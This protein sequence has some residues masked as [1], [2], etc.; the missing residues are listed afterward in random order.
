MEPDFKYWA[1][2]SYS[3]RDKAWADWLHS[4]LEGF[5]VPAR[6]RG[7]PSRDGFV[8]RRL[9]PCF[10]DREELPSSASLGDNI[11]DALRRS[12]YLI[13]ICSPRSAVSEWVNKEVLYFKS[14]GREDRVLCLIVDGEPNAVPGSGTLECFP[15]AVRFRVNAQAEI[16]PGERVEPIAADVR[17][18]GDG[19]PNAKLKLLAGLLGV[20]FDELKQRERR[21]VI[22]R[23]LVRGAVAAVLLGVGTWWLL[24]K[25]TLEI[26]L[27]PKPAPR[28]LEFTVDG[29]PETLASERTRLRLPAGN[30]VLRFSAPDHAP[31]TELVD[32]ERRQRR[33]ITA[34][35]AHLQGTLNVEVEPGAAQLE[36]DGKPFG[37]RIDFLSFDT[38]EHVVRA[39]L[40]GHYERTQRVTLREGETLNAYLSLDP[41]REAWHI[42]R[43]DVQGAF[44]N[45][46]DVDGDGVED[47]AHNFITQVG[48]ISGRTGRIIRSF[49][50]S[51]GNA[52]PFN[53]WDLGGSVGRILLSVGTRN[54]RA[55]DGR[56]LIDML[57]LRGDRDQPLW[58]WLSPIPPEAGVQLAV[59]GDQN[60]DGVAE[61]VVHGANDTYFLVDGATGRDLGTGKLGTTNEWAIA[62]WVARCP[63]PQG[64]ALLFCGLLPPGGSGWGE[65]NYRAGLVLI[66]DGR[67]LWEETYERSI[68]FQM[69]EIEGK[70]R[71]AITLVTRTDWLVI[72]NANGKPKWRGAL[73]RTDI[74]RDL[75]GFWFADLDGDGVKEWLMAFRESIAE[76]E[77]LLAAVRLRDGEVLW[78][79][80]IRPTAIQAFEE[81]ALARTAEGGLLFRLETAVVSL[82]PATGNER[83]RVP[84][85]PSGD[86]DLRL[87]DFN[88][89]GQREIVVGVLDKGIRVLG[90]DG[91]P[92]WGVWLDK[93]FSP[94]IVLREAGHPE[95]ARL[96]LNHHDG[97]EK[98]AC[99]I[100][101]VSAP[102]GGG[103][104]RRVVPE[105]ALAAAGRSA[106]SPRTIA[107]GAWVAQ[108][109][110]R[111]PEQPNLTAFDPAT[112][113]R[114]WTVPEVFESES[115][116]AV[117]DW[118][119]QPAL[120]LLGHVPR[121]ISYT[122]LN[123][124]S[125]FV[126]RGSDGKQLAAIPIEPWG[127]WQAT[128]VLAD[129]DGDNHT[130]FVVVRPRL[131]NPYTGA[132][133]GGDVIAVNGAKQAQMWRVPFPQPAALA[134]VGTGA[135]A[136]V[137]VT[138]GDGTLVALT[139]RDGTEVWRARGSGGTGAVAT[140]AAGSNLAGAVF[141]LARDGSF[142]QLDLRTGDVRRQKRIADATKGFGPPVC[143]PLPA[144]PLV[145]VACGATG[146]VAL[147]ALT[148][149]ERWRS[150]AG[151]SVDAP[152]FVADLDSDG[153]LEVVLCSEA[154]D[155]MV[156]DLSTG[157]V[158]RKDSLVESTDGAEAVR[159]V[160]LLTVT[161]ARAGIPARLLV[162][163]SDGVLH[164]KV[165]GDLRK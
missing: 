83:W 2:V 84:N 47:F 123:R 53:G 164:T 126:Y 46:G 69:S 7:R 14:L 49:P 91:S 102:R 144:D 76:P 100:V 21:R 30:H 51:D 42:E 161:P 11:N 24:Q 60:G 3:H 141:A 116:P 101:C 99:E 20:N 74:S 140:F 57:C 165:L 155:V 163:C 19:K 124:T 18:Q 6:L 59:I 119:G 17:P 92:R 128:P 114:Q 40:A 45:V 135:G 109:S 10:R 106:G 112:G 89:D 95:A 35:L 90:P 151:E 43:W 1:F 110:I 104:S 25:G 107:A 56:P 28:G 33:S 125:L 63:T 111:P 5:R 27:S 68:G 149:A 105:N 115:T 48:I 78:R 61:I 137:I 81:G 71:P 146:V 58:R 143:V 62:P 37:G 153:R 147:D 32:L 38:G 88:G 73:P 52:R 15:P 8:P 4:S 16:V 156:L 9:Y 97:S 72:D 44:I 80:T 162:L 26:E 93:E 150:P 31:V 145:L 98:R 34:R 13:V 134:V 122:G 120:A 55:S 94:M 87:L 50:T 67:L 23:S 85:L 70:D 75:M 118:E 108:V 130:D 113:V 142:S 129:L 64:D 127:N 154:G 36:V 133:L 121:D 160:G 131:I 103:W 65:R 77:P 96:I 79:K 132:G 152:P 66:K 158:L 39:T 12:R 41:A 22:R 139:G 159:P 117:G 29:R 54:Y 148:L 157:T 86:T 136:I 82:D 138:L